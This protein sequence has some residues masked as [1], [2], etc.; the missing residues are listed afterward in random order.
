M[1]PQA[2]GLASSQLEVPTL[3]F[4]V[5][6]A[7]AYVALWPKPLDV[8]TAT[9]IKVA[10]ISTNKSLDLG[11]SEGESIFYNLFKCLADLS[12]GDLIDDVP[13][14]QRR[15]TFDRIPNDN[16]DPDSA[17]LFTSYGLLAI[18]GSVF[19]AIHLVAWNFQFPTSIEQNLWR[20]ASVLVTAMPTLLSALF[21]FELWGMTFFLG[22]LGQVDDRLTVFLVRGTVYILTVIYIFARLFIFAEALASLRCL[23]EEAYYVVTWARYIPKFQ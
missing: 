6:T 14:S 23:P 10:S 2:Q 7:A 18:A 19:G 8:R 21:Y 4:A 9:E 1:H 11:H 16:V 13:R 3:A 17:G 20:T 12:L 5:C 15:S 22:F